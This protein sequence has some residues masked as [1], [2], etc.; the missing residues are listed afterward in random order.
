MNKLEN[1]KIQREIV[2][3]LKNTDEC[4]LGSLVRKLNYSYNQILTNVMELI[5][6]GDIQ[7]LEGHNGYFSLEKDY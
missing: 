5:Q 6:K 1:R 3:Q 4:A 7:K 2:E